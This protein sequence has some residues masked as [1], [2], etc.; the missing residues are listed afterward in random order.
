VPYVGGFG[1]DLSADFVVKAFVEVDV[2]LAV[3][4]ALVLLTICLAV[5]FVHAARSIRQEHEAR[6]SRIQRRLER[7]AAALVDRLLRRD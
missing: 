3:V 1:L 2:R 5:G 4:G 7:D 6:F